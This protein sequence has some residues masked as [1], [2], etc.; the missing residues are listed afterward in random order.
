V[1]LAKAR[2]GIETVGDTHIQMDNIGIMEISE[3]RFMSQA[4]NQMMQLTRGVDRTDDM[5]GA[6]MREESME[7][8][9]GE[10]D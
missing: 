1:R 3:I 2:K 6:D 10:D 8:S 7:G 4:V 9:V 5:E